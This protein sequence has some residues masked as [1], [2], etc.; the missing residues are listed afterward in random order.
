MHV[1]CTRN[2][3]TR[4]ARRRMH[5]RNPCD[6]PSNEITKHNHPSVGSHTSS[7]SKDQNAASLAGRTVRTHAVSIIHLMLNAIYLHLR[8]AHLVGCRY[9]EFTYVHTHTHTH[10]TTANTTPPTTTINSLNVQ[11]IKINVN[12]EMNEK[13]GGSG[14]KEETKAKWFREP[15]RRQDERMYFEMS[16]N[17]SFNDAANN[18]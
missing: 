18:V 14:G 9:F 6:S 5:S 10:C 4:N 3:H 1:Q 15:R 17:T 13:R 7:N 8:N 12:V 2:T 11:P 16:W